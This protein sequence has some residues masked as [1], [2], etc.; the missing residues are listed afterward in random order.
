MTN[1]TCNSGATYEGNLLKVCGIQCFDS[2][3]TDVELEALQGLQYSVT[4]AGITILTND[5]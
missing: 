2:A 4:K 1:M 3:T 5:K